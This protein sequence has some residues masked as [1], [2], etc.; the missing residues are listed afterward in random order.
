MAKSAIGKY[1]YYVHY[2]ACNYMRKEGNLPNGEL[3]RYAIR[4]VQDRA[5]TLKS[6]ISK[7]TKEEYAKTIS[8]LYGRKTDS[9][10]KLPDWNAFSNSLLEILKEKYDSVTDSAILLK[11]SGRLIASGRSSRSRQKKLI[12]RRYLTQNQIKELVQLMENLDISMR[13]PLQG[14]QSEFDELKTKLELLGRKLEIA[15]KKM[16]EGLAAIEQDPDWKMLKG[17]DKKTAAQW[18]FDLGKDNN[19]L[20]YDINSLM[21]SCGLAYVALSTAQGFAGEAVA[22]MSAEIVAGL[23]EKTLEKDLEPNF[24]LLA[25]ENIMKGSISP[26]IKYKMYGDSKHWP[27]FLKDS[28]EV[29]EDKE[30]GGKTVVSKNVSQQKVDVAVQLP[31]NLTSNKKIPVNISMKSVDLRRAIGLVSGTNLWYLISDENVKDFLRPYL[32][33]TAGHLGDRQTDWKG[34]NAKVVA[35]EMVAANKIR[36]K[37][38]DALKAVQIL[39]AY[40]AISGDIYGRTAAQLF[41]VNDVNGKKTYVLEINDIIQAILR[42]ITEKGGKIEKYFNFS[43]Q[44][45]KDLLLDNFY[46]S[47]AQGGIHGRIGQLLSSAHQKKI[48]VLMDP[49]I[50]SLLNKNQLI[51]G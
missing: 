51:T 42:N 6:N 34:A 13:K 22:A 48:S 38:Q 44:D 4:K 41:V 40:K 21:Q 47:K 1:A 35:E 33:I 18:R 10:Y 2:S 15:T 3:S 9:K 20:L 11:E 16:I 24:K 29:I 43:F 28:K 26:N 7:K 25:D 12:E 49:D 46:H 45:I 8:A 14:K 5:K 23:V 27:E 31:K 17:I 32:N 30:S 19:T 37:R 39:S 36:A 50:T